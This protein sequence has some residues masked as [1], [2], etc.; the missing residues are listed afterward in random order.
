M[1]IIFLDI[2][3]VLNHQSC[4]EYRHK[5]IDTKLVSGEYPKKGYI[6]KVGFLII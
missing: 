5:N 4:Y 3:G 2:D 1:K 6:E